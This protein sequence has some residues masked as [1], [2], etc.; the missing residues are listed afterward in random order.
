MNYT[1]A[2]QKMNLHEKAAQ[3]IIGQAEGTD[4]SSG[5]AEFI[6][7]YK[8]GGYRV[9]GGNYE[10][11]A[12]L[13]NFTGN[14]NKIYESMNI[15]QPLL[16][17]DQ[18]GGTLTVFRNKMTIFPT[19]LALGSTGDPELAFLQA[20]I[21]GDELFNAGINMA[22]APV[23]D[24]NLQP[25]NSVIGVRAFGDS[26]ATVA[27]FC[28]KYCEGL[29]SAGILNSI[30]HFP[31]HGNTTSDSHKGAAVNRVKTFEE[32]NSTELFPFR[33]CVE[34]GVVDTVMVSHVALPEITAESEPASVSVKIIQGMLRDKIGYN[35]VVISDD[36]E[37]GAIINNYEIGDAAVKFILAGGD[38]LLI[39]QKRESQISA[40]EKIVKAVKDGVIGEERLNESL[41]RIF[42][43]K[44]KSAAMKIDRKI[45]Y[46]NKSEVVKQICLHAVNTVRDSN[47][48]LPWAITDKKIVVINPI[49]KNLTEADTSGGLKNNLPV[50]L[51][52]YFSNVEELRISLSEGISDEKLSE[53]TENF[54]LAVIITVNIQL[55]REQ[56]KMIKN[57]SEFMDTIAVISRDPYDVNFLPEEC[58][59]IASYSSD[60]FSMMRA[61]EIIAGK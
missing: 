14:I 48:I 40:I 21:I 60:D 1:D 17:S 9:S 36:M 56:E 20:N 52:K 24:V 35:G 2:M 31:G 42:M 43:L 45:F 10:S 59:V 49:Q 55:F 34:A 11:S 39:N 53:I 19:T 26:P 51:K 57:I 4:V 54:S 13:K 44:E 46:K 27:K 38:I 32:L 8:L 18:E 61:A 28:V 3:L 29:N 41:R 58:A 37:M 5:F 7:K 33:K 23:A 12:Q 50:Y 47:K 25:Q 15:P 22:F 30:K 16:G 6:E